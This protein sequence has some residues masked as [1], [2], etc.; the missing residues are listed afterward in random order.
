MSV[1]KITKEHSAP[2][3]QIP[4]ELI[5]DPRVSQSGFRLMAYLMSHSEGYELTLEQIQRETGLGRHSINEGRKNLEE[6]GWLETMQNKRADGKYEKKTWILKKPTAA[7]FPRTETPV[8]AESAHKNTNKELKKTNKEKT[9]N[10]ENPYWLEF[11]EIYPRKD[12]KKPAMTAFGNLTKKNQLLALDGAKAY[13]VS[14]LPEDKFIPQA[15]TWLNQER[16]LNDY[17]PK[18]SGWNF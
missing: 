1:I 2:Y 16:W 14:D 10:D 5:R 11:W 9:V 8:T 18:K 15:A 17:T 13:A 3:A 12:N 7:G 6:L 4:N